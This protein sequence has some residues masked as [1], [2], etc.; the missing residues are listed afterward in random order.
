MANWKQ[1]E[2]VPGEIVDRQN[3]RIKITQSESYGLYSFWKKVDFWKTMFIYA[4]GGVMLLLMLTYCAQTT[5]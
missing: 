2:R 4:C 3:K 5:N 1:R